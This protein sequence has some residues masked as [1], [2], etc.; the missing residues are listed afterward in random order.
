MDDFT[1]GLREISAEDIN[2]RF[3]WGRHLPALGTMGVDFEERID[4]RRLHRYR[5][6][7]TRQALAKSG[8]G[9]LLV[10]DQY[11]IR[12]MTSTR[13]AIGSATSSRYALLP[14]IANRSLGFRLGGEA[15]SALRA[16]A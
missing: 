1:R 2:P 14:A 8:L 12:Y 6:G 15:P 16:L 10:F 7:R 3:N 9:S 13:S 11:N 5:L 4:F